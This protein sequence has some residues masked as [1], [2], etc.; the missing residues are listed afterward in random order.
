MIFMAM[1]NLFTLFYAILHL[2]HFLDLGQCVLECAVI[3]YLFSIVIIFISVL[4]N[5]GIYVRIV[6]VNR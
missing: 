1:T 6:P 5:G 2:I 3:N 4:A